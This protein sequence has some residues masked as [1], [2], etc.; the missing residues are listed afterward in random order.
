MPDTTRTTETVTATSSSV[1][2]ST[3]QQQDHRTQSI[4]RS[5][6]ASIPALV[7]EDDDR[8]YLNYGQL[9]TFFK[10]GIT[11]DEVVN[12]VI[13]RVRTHLVRL[14]TNTFTIHLVAQ[15]KITIREFTTCMR[16][17]ILNLA[18]AFKAHCPTALDACHIYDGPYFLT[19]IRDVLKMVVR[20]DM[21]DRIQVH[22]TTTNDD[23]S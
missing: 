14:N 4:V 22:A 23:T 2:S 16:E 6:R 9:P 7:T 20:K 18:Q 5:L 11:Y 12:E 8:V 15:R 19:A 21:L 10:W 13:D 17:F 3:V 1:D